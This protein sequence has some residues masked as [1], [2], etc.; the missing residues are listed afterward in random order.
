MWLLFM[1]ESVLPRM[2]VAQEV[3]Q[4]SDGYGMLASHVALCTWAWLRWHRSSVKKH[5]KDQLTLMHA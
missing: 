4:L 3:K 5:R 1:P 2:T